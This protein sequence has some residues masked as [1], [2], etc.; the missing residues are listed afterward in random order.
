MQPIVFIRQTPFRILVNFEAVHLHQATI[1]LYSIL[2]G[3]VIQFGVDIISGD[4]QTNA[5]T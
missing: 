2:V 4:G 5:R 3:D 1:L